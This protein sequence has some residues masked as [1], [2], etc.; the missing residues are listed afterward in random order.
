MLLHV[1]RRLAT[2]PALCFIALGGC[3]LDAGQGA[4]GERPVEET[5]AEI[6]AGFPANS[7]KLNAVGALGIYYEDP[8]SGSTYFDPFCSGALI[9]QRTVLT[10][11]HCTDVFSYGFGYG[12]KVG[13]GIGPNG[14]APERIVEIIDMDRAPGDSGGFV[15]YGHDVGVFYLGEAV[16]DITP[17]RFRAPTEAQVGKDFVAIGYGVQ[18]NNGSYGT[19]RLGKVE[20]RALEGRVFEILF[21]SFEAFYEWYTGEPLPPDGGG[22]AGA[23]GGGTGGAGGT[24]GGGG[25]AGAGGEPSG[26]SGGLGGSGPGG[27]DDW[28]IEYLRMI[29]E[30]TVLDTGYEVI[31]GGTPGDAQPCYGD[32][33]SPLLRANAAGELVIFGVV[34]GGLGSSTQVCDYGAV[35]A[36][37]GEGVDDF[38][39]AS[40]RYVDP[41]GGLSY[42][43]TCDDTV[44]R[45]CTNPAEGRR[46]LV[47]FDCALVGEACVV[48]SS[49][50]VGCG[51][52]GGGLPPAPEPTEPPSI[53]ALRAHVNEVFARGMLSRE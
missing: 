20:L 47:E 18:D 50:E 9:G 35:Y 30:T 48:Q 41:C 53:E 38:V 16:T 34:S 2:I 44:A 51:E 37:F 31:V 52:E 39:R 19:R 43:G 40:R 22:E 13:F 33:G 4:P 27:E 3:S 15:G 24:A 11:K 14:H 23:G 21:G 1:T 8:W 25:T 32:S 45:R 42:T 6:I 7:P 10:A 29:Y 26:G 12:Y 17:L 49:G 28:I 5:A 46:R 36:T